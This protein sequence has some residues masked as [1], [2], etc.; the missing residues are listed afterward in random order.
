VIS[1]KWRTAAGVV[2]L[3]GSATG[4]LAQYAMAPAHISGGSA[5]EQV[6]AADGDAAIALC[7]E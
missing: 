5:A 7:R 1:S 2:A 3:L 6:A 4:E